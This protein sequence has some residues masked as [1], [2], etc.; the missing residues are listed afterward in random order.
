MLIAFFLLFGVA[1][2]SYIMGN[3]IEILNS[4]E[5]ISGD[6]NYG[7]ELSNFFGV[8]N[9]FNNCED[10]DQDMKERI[11]TYFDYRWTVDKNYIV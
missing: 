5:D 9:K 2:F 7:D 6:I 11:E 3:F 4:F 1:C 10:I 8:L